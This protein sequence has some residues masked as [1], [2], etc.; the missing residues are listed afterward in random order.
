MLRRAMLSPFPGMDPYLEA[1]WSNVHTTHIALIQEILQPALP[2]G[3]R[4]RAEERVLLQSRRP[5]RHRLHA[6][7]GTTA[8][9]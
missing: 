7:A 5:R 2:F 8:R 9:W 6:T 4:A 3:L 1:R